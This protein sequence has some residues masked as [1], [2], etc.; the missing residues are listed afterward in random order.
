VVAITGPLVLP[1][2]SDTVN[3]SAPSVVTSASAVTVNEPVLF[4]IANEPD[5]ILDVKSNVF[6]VILFT[7]Q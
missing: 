7:V 2:L 6:A 5:T 1:V 4:A 3:V